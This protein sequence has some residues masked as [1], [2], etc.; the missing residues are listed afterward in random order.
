M[1]VQPYAGESNRYLV[2]SD[3]RPEMLHVVDMEW[4]ECPGDQPRPLCGCEQ[5]FAKGLLCK[6]IKAVADYLKTKL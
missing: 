6:H 4:V 1:K 2:Q 5:S 3:S